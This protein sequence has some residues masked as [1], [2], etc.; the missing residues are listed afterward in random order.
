MK[1]KIENS[2]IIFDAIELLKEL[3]GEEQIG[4]IESLSCQ[5]AVIKH[6]AD[7]I[8]H[9]CTDNG[10]YGYSGCSET[11]HTPL[12]VAKRFVAEHSGEVAKREI[13]HLENL[14]KLKE[15]SLSEAWEKIHKLEDYVARR[16]R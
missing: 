4:L 14:V 8:I 10:Y 9:R 6:V 15:K 2:K 5:D 3:S 16:E 1:V 7:Q 11:P 12:D 13:R